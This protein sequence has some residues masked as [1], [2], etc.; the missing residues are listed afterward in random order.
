[1]Y[2]FKYFN[3]F[4]IFFLFFFNPFELAHADKKG[5]H[6]TSKTVLHSETSPTQLHAITPDT[7]EDIDPNRLKQKLLKELGVDRSCAGVPESNMTT[8][9]ITNIV[10]RDRVY[11][12]VAGRGLVCVSPEEVARSGVRHFKSQ[13]QTPPKGLEYT[14]IEGH[15]DAETHG[16]ADESN[17]LGGYG[18]L[19]LDISEKMIRVPIV[20]ATEDNLRY[21]KAHLVHSGDYFRFETQ[22]QFPIFDMTVG[23]NYVPSFIM[24]GKGLYLEYHD[25]PHYHEPM[26]AQAGGVYLLA[27]MVK[28]SASGKDLVRISGFRVPFGSAVYSEP[29]A[30]HDD[31]T[32]QG[33][34]RVGYVNA[35]DFSTVLIRNNK[36]EKVGM[37]F[38][39]SKSK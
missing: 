2:L 7:I 5:K 18:Q 25:E 37:D 12:F 32:T 34:W 16:G 3:Y 17:L 38:Q 39:E 20:E 33:H 27:R 9:T 24:N 21:Y 31:A 13:L 6:S 23:V 19:T 36:S 1:M 8:H 30:I 35:K 14:D 29:G 15:W 11:K 22:S 10:N 26:D 28:D 4:L